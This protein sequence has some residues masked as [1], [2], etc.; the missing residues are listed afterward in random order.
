MIYSLINRY[1]IICSKHIYNNQDIQQSRLIN[2]AEIVICPM[3]CF[4][5]HR[6]IMIHKKQSF[7]QSDFRAMRLP[8]TFLYTLKRI[9]YQR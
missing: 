3:R 4:N 9:E 8:D 5:L 2:P 1:I 6:G 7:I